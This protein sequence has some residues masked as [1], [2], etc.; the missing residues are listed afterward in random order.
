MI[1]WYRLVLIVLLAPSLTTAATSQSVSTTYVGGY[2]VPGAFFFTAIELVDTGGAV[3]GKMHQPFDRADTPPLQDLITNGEKLT[4]NVDHLYFVLQ[5]TAYGYSGFVRDQKGKREQKAEFIK[6]RTPTP[7]EIP[8]TP[9]YYSGGYGTPGNFVYT[10]IGFDTGK[11]G[12]PFDRTDQPPIRNL[13]VRN[14][15]LRFDADRLHFELTQFDHGARGWVV[16]EKG[17]RRP[18]YFVTRPKDI[19]SLE[20]LERYEGTYRIGKRRLLTLSRNVFSDSFHYLELPSGRTGAL[21]YRPNGELTGG[22]C[23]YCPGPEYLRVSLDPRQSGRAQRVRVTID[24]RTIDAPRIETHSEEEIRFISKD[25]TQLAGSL[26]LPSGKGPH[27]AVVFAHGS[28]AQ[29]RNGFY[30]NIRFIAEAYARSGIAAL[31]FDKRGTG[32]SKGDWKT[33]NLEILGDDVAAGV[34][35]LRTRAEIRADRIGLTG[36]SQAGWIMSFAAMRVPDVRFIQMRSSSPMSVREANRD[37]LVLMMEAERYPRSEIQRALNIRDMIDDYAVTGQNWEQLEAAAKQVENEYWM[38]QFI[39]GLPAKDSTTYAWLRKAFSY[40]V[41]AAVRNFKGAWQAIY[42]ASDIVVSVP[43]TRAW[44]E[45]ALR[46]GR[47]NDVTIEVVPNAD[48]NYYE[49]K[50]GLD[51]RELPGYSRYVPGIF[52]KITRW[53]NERMRN[54]YTHPLSPGKT[55][56]R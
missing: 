37:Q 34:E 14:G 31:I 21:F 27:P 54:T 26:L 45:D 20:V 1:T 39:G 19:P 9:T 12:Q 47:S 44:L 38:T 22:P 6:R 4:F 41:T 18:A 23:M 24:G 33:A 25:G 42:G 50:T 11:I 15:Q 51:H 48:H 29:T 55:P 30:G 32:R 28:S 16:D 52:D 40:D 8:T 2:G 13:T 10:R 46:D 35:F 7:R 43:K 3:S 53:A 36:S 17:K 5:R 49:T 56:S